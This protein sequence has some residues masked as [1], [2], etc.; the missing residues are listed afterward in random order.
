MII[1]NQIIKVKINEIVINNPI[2][3]LLLFLVPL[4][5]EEISSIVLF[6]LSS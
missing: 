2:L 3:P 4:L 1:I 5:N 6:S